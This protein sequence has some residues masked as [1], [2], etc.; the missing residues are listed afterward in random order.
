MLLPADKRLAIVEVFKL[1]WINQYRYHIIRLFESYEY[2][3]N[4]FILEM[5]KLDY[6]KT[7]L[8]K[9]DYGYNL[10]PISKKFKPKPKF[11]RNTSQQRNK[12]IKQTIKQ[13]FGFKNYE[14]K[15]KYELITYKTKS[16]KKGI[17][18]K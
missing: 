18:V 11:Q 5:Q 1:S 8:S 14:C 9:H 17:P 4:K 3:Q 15:S 6:L 10:A 12:P 16:I 13:G 2:D 7:T